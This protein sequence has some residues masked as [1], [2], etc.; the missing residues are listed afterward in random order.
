MEV[1]Y[2]FMVLSGV[3]FISR[4]MNMN[5]LVLKKVRIQNESGIKFK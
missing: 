2:S 3:L 1:M 4:L 5:K